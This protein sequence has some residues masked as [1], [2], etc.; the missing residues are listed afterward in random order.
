M[1][2]MIPL[3]EPIK[4]YQLIDSSKGKDVVKNPSHI[5]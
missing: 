5:F 3:D 2:I 1:K 4:C